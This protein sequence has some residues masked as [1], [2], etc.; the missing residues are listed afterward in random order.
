[1]KNKS[2]KHSILHCALF[3]ERNRYFY[4]NVILASFLSCTI[5]PAAQA[6]VDNTIESQ[7]VTFN[8][9]FFKGTDKS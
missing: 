4:L 6:D 9:G 5:I 1:M 7:D 3:N 8:S 2:F